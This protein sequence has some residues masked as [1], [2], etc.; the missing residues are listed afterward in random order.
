[1]QEFDFKRC[2]RKCDSSGRDIEAGER[3]VSAI[4]DDGD[5]ILRRDYSEGEW[6]NPPEGCLG[7]WRSQVPILEKGK[8]YWAPN[9]VLMAY[10]ESVVT[11]PEQK[12]TAYVMALLLVRKRIL[13]WKDTISQD[14]IESMILRH[15]GSKST[16][17]VEVLKVSPDQ[18][19]SIQ[20]ELA[21]QLF[22]DVVEV[23]PADDD[24][25]DE[26]NS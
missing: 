6:E 4:I 16:F 10:F 24:D 25:L 12:N 26:A 14:E 23:E 9:W 19:L 1:M 8:I 22:T 13:Q 7:W 15:S 21:E 5:E 3:Y 2:T 11:K 18:I 17:E 20:N